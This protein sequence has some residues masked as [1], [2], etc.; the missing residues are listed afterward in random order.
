MLGFRPTPS[1]G[2]L[3]RQRASVSARAKVRDMKVSHKPKL[4]PHQQVE[5]IKLRDAGEPVREV[6]R[7]FNVYHTTNSSLTAQAAAA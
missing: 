7:S 6:T 3:A 5:V 2:A 1:A 4:A